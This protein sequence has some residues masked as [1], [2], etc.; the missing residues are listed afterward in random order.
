M[1]TKAQAPRTTLTA[2][3]QARNDKCGSNAGPTSLGLTS[4]TND[5][6]T[7]S[8]GT[9]VRPQ[10]HLKEERVRERERET[11]RDQETPMKPKERR[12]GKEVVVEVESLKP[13]V[14]LEE[15]V[16]VVEVGTVKTKP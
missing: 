5:P 9:N 7:W 10:T 6:S 13:L 12:E 1:G 11:T 15:K 14:W 3:T 4:T 16:V 8:T 2:S